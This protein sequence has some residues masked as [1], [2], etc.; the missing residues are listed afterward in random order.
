MK[1]ISKFSLALLGVLAFSASSAR[2]EAPLRVDDLNITAL[3][4]VS[5]ASGNPPTT[6]DTKLYDKRPGPLGL[7]PVIA[8]DG[9]RKSVV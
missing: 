8:P 9:D 7:T 1:K 3:L 4:Q 6:P 5:D 2:A